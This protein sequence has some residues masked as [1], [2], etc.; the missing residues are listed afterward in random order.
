MSCRDRNVWIVE[1]RYASYHFSRFINRFKNEENCKIKR[2][3]FDWSWFERTRGLAF[4][5][6]I[7]ADEKFF[8]SLSNPLG[9]FVNIRKGH[10]MYDR[11]HNRIEN[12]NCPVMRERRVSIHD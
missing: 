12:L 11:L 8:Y 3:P 1:K 5:H 7:L 4:Y 6:R 10:F 2:I 9:D